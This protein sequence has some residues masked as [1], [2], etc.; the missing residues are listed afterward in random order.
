MFAFDEKIVEGDNSIEILCKKAQS[1]QENEDPI[2]VSI[3]LPT[4]SKKVVIH[5]DSIFSYN[6][7]DDFKAK[8]YLL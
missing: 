4:V 5:I 8:K 6:C 7:N 1:K 2:H 3:L